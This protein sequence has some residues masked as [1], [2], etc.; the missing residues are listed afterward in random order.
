MSWVIR[1]TRR[2]SVPN[3]VQ[4]NAWGSLGRYAHFSTIILFYICLFP[5]NSLQV[6]PL[7]WSWRTIHQN[8]LNHAR[9]KNTQNI[10]MWSKKWTWKIFSQYRLTMAM[11]ISKLPLTFIVAS[12]KLYSEQAN[13]SQEI[14]IWGHRWPLLTGHVTQPNFGP[15]IG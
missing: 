2:P 10:E 9:F 11:I 4:I 7:N 5:S 14:Q 3:L 13:R 15:K 1:S 6:R 8:T 12:W